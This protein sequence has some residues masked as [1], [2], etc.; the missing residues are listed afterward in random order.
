[1]A[2]ITCRCG[3]ALSNQEAPS[4]IELVVYTD[5]EWAEICDCDS[6]QPWMIPSPRYEVWRCPV[7]KRSGHPNYGLS[8]RGIEP[9]RWQALNGPPAGVFM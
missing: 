1:M 7:C 8:A 4:D 9:P 6:I 3:A 5:K 2:R